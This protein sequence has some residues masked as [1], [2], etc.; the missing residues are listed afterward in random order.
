MNQP[1]FIFDLGKVLVDFDWSIAAR[2]IIQRSR[3]SPEQFTEYLATSPL[4]WQYE[5]GQ[6]SRADF[7]AAISDLTDFQGTATEFNDYFAEIF[8]EIPPMIALQTSLRERGF[9]TYIF[10]NT[11]DLAIEHIR[12]DFPFFKNFD[13]YIFSYEVGAMKPQP[14]IY[15]AMEA[16][17]GRRGAD[18]IYLDDRR[19]NIEAGHARGWSTILHET[20]E[21]T[22]FS[23][24]ALGFKP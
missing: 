13:G 11:N 8:T 4:L 16:M 2:K 7:F 6:I 19:E 14:K 23:L 17:S 1:V 5:C 3:R 22:L 21:K 9:K 15:E 24:A 18:L 12:R 10:S 20:P